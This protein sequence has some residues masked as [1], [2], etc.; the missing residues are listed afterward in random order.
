ME[1]PTVEN[2]EHGSF[3]HCSS[4]CYRQECNQSESDGQLEFFLLFLPR[5]CLVIIFL[6]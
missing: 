2:E 4:I 3:E 1:P 6:S 5:V